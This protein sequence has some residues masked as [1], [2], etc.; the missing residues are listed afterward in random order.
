M[1]S[2]EKEFCSLSLYRMVSFLS[3]VCPWCAHKPNTSLLWVPRDTQRVAAACSF[4]T[5][6][7]AAH[8]QGVGVGA[9]DEGVLF[10]APPWL[11]TVGESVNIDRHPC[12]TVNV[13]YEFQ[14]FYYLFNL[15]GE[16]WGLSFAVK[17][18]G[19]SHGFSI[20]SCTPMM[21]TKKRF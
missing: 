18:E 11:N 14:G 20:S 16:G 8:T 21:E 3:L 12:I 5:P 15:E 7:W 2:R 1:L 19:C 10:N 17:D 9:V 6:T 4:S 13:W